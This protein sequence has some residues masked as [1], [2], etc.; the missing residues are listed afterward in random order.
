MP[1]ASSKVV[2]FASSH[3]CTE[4][5]P[6]DDGTRRVLMFVAAHPS[7]PAFGELPVDILEEATIN[8]ERLKL[9]S[10]QQQCYE[11]ALQQNT[12]I[13]LPTGKG[14]T[15]VA[16]RILET[17]LIDESDKKALFIVPTR[18]LVEQ[19]AQYCRDHIDPSPI[20]AELCGN[21]LEAWTRRDWERCLTSSDVLLGTPEVF[22]NALTQHG[23]LSLPQFSLMI[24]DEAHNAT[25]NSPMAAIM[26][27]AFQ[28]RVRAG[29]IVPRV[30][31]LTASYVSGALTN[32]TKKRE[33]L[34]TLMHSSLFSPPALD[35]ESLDED[36]PTLIKVDYAADE[37]DGIKQVADGKVQEL[38]QSF[39][40]LGRPG[41]VHDA[42]K[43]AS[44]AMHVLEQVGMSGFT[45]Y[46]SESVA[47]QLQAHAEEMAFR[48]G[49]PACQR[50]AKELSATLPAI[51]EACR[52]KAHALSRTGE[53][54][55]APFI[56]GKCLRLLNL[57][58]E[59]FARHHSNEQYR[60]IIFVEQ[61][62]LT[63]PLAHVLNHHLKK[64]RASHGL[65]DTVCAN[66]V[67]GTGTM[68]DKARRHA[69]D[70][71]KRGR[72][73]VLVCTASLEE[74]IDV[75]ECEFV[76][77]FSLF[78]T[79]K[80]HIQGSGRARHKESE[81]YYFD[82]EP[83]R[84]VELAK[85]LSL[86]AR[87]DSLRLTDEE[88]IRRILENERRIPGVHPF[89]PPGF[90]IAVT[91]YNCADIV[92]TFI[93]KVYGSSVNL[94]EFMTFNAMHQKDGSTL[95]TSMQYP[96]AMGLVTVTLKDVNRYWG[97]H[98]VSHVVDSERTKNMTRH[99]LERKRFLF[100]VAVDMHQRGT[101]DQ[102]NLPTPSAIIGARAMMASNPAAEA[103]PMAMAAKGGVHLRDVFAPDSLE[104]ASGSRF[105]GSRPE[106]SQGMPPNP[107]TRP[108]LK[109]P[110]PVDLPMPSTLLKSR[111]PQSSSE[112]TSMAPTM[113]D[114][115]SQLNAKA[116]AL[117]KSP[118]VTYEYDRVGE[119][120]YRSRVLLK[121]LPNH[122]PLEGSTESGK[123]AAAQS[124][125][126]AALQWLNKNGQ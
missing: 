114:Y 86:S 78:K 45:F 101:L 70:Q 17:Y 16:V 51:R 126:N 29:E 37:I 35:L 22:K 90:D 63:F 21:K 58:E 115:K 4:L 106:S 82:N 81:V 5:T 117:W 88:R 123:A 9:R 30:I 69:L 54:T 122:P 76:V 125:A 32:I 119:Q 102:S 3:V 59:L 61:V 97:D 42:G 20:V 100:V 107:S 80:A 109:A 8:H 103:P 57:I 24:F 28:P 94:E 40:E 38:I 111:P 52:S 89:Q 105:K 60:G 49:D 11:R 6:D 124:A 34:E 65:S 96:S 98:D 7:L 108:Q 48:E 25:G 13:C 95:Q 118:A 53:L 62:A 14:K 12:I 85:T 39:S 56:S 99:E 1:H 43:V 71:F 64:V 44:H 31:G 74:G 55:M 66:A 73:R 26:R 79:T 47:Y 10:Y 41:V 113:A 72:S 77:R 27:D 120:L 36:S 46:L 116:N 50:K 92:S 75:K 67:S 15:L 104:G 121:K 2:C 83:D 110:S 18:A 19:Q 23:F 33:Q 93:S 91:I 68:S 87:D 84:E 112:P